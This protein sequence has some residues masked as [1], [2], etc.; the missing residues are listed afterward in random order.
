MFRP[1]IIPV[2]L[3]KGKGLVKTVRFKDPRYIGDPINAVRIFNDLEADELVFLDIT[4]SRENRC[5][6]LDLVRQIGDE[7]FMP[8]AV[9]GGIT[10]PDQ[11]ERLFKAGAEKVV[12]NTGAVENPRLIEEAAG[13]FGSQSIIVSIDVK[14]T[15]FKRQKVFVRDGREKTLLDPVTWAR[16]AEDLGA[17]EIMIHAMDRDGTMTGYDLELVR[18]VSDAVSVPVIACGGAGS[19]EDFR[20]GFDRGKA[21]ALAAGSLFVYHGPRKAV[22][23]NYPSRA[24]I[25][26]LFD[27]RETKKK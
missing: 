6:S 7:A 11:M 4:A 22:L 5:V 25:S 8:F 26:A 17:G 19:V 10:G 20:H 23:V 9:G 13:H 12:I 21:H 15:L 18:Q 1:R 3:L 24:E 2:L 14:Q 16:E 27:N